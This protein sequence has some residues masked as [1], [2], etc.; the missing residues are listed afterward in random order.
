M[1][2]GQGHKAND[3]FAPKG[4]WQSGVRADFFALGYDAFGALL[5]GRNYSARARVSRVHAG[6]HTTWADPPGSMSSQAVRGMT[7]TF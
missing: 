3:V 2:H 7:L 5:S 6:I 4:A 1:T